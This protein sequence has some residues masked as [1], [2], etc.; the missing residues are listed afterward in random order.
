MY[1]EMFP[2]EELARLNDYSPDILGLTTIDT[3][4]SEICD[5]VQPGAGEL[6]FQDRSL[7]KEEKDI[8]LGSLF[9]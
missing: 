8:D 4:Y 1:G 3:I 5:W 2:E 6:V 9:L 7:S